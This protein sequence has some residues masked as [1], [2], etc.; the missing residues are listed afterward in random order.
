VGSRAGTGERYATQVGALWSGLAHTLTRLEAIAA[1]PERLEDERQVE[2]LRR[3]QY[4]LHRASEH[5]FGL[6]P[7]AGTEPVH[8]ELAGAL[9]GARDATGRIVEAVDEWGPDA[10]EPLVWEWRGALFRVRLA[11]L[12]LAGEAPLGPRDETN[13]PRSLK[14]PLTAFALILVGSGMF[15]AGAMSKLWPIWVAG[16]VAVCSSVFAFRR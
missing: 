11:R 9:A 15:V 1:E 5:A 8:T 14:A 2:L 12:R 4:G 16:M 6:S 7:P 13:R 3:L 10:A